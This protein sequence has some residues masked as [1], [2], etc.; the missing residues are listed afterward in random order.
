M[1]TAAPSRTR[2]APTPR[3]PYQIPV[4]QSPTVPLQ[5]P[6]RDPDASPPRPAPPR[7]EDDR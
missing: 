6:L 1:T 2:P 3:L 4:R 5:V 7:K